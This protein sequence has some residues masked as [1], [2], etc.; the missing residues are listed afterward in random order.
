MH[1]GSDARGDCQ[2]NTV[3]FQIPITT[4][5]VFERRVRE[6]Q[7]GPREASGVSLIEPARQLVALSGLLTL[8]FFQVG[9]E[10]YN[11]IFWVRTVCLSAQLGMMV[12]SAR[13]LSQSGFLQVKNLESP[14]AT[15]VDQ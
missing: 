8:Q 11:T 3:L 4:R 5:T 9:E 15:P 2:V 6:S 7:D 14:L 1:Y 10:N 12:W 13:A